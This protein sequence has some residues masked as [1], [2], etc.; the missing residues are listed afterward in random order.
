M[1]NNKTNSKHNID[2][3]KMSGLFKEIEFF[4]SEIKENMMIFQNLNS[5][6]KN[7]FILNAKS[8]LIN[9]KNQLNNKNVSQPFK[10]FYQNLLDSMGEKI[11]KV[12]FKKKFIFK[13]L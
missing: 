4:E 11:E 2:I 12:F 13:F 10:E 1:K 3:K 7:E 9:F 5:Y 8:S 6:E